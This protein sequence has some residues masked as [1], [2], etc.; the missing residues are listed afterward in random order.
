MKRFCGEE[1]VV[2]DWIMRLFSD[3][4]KKLISISGVETK[5][6]IQ[7]FWIDFVRVYFWLSTVFLW[8]A[9]EENE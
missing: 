1:A 9:F 2:K 4:N 3:A 6:W 7:E 8:S 5:K